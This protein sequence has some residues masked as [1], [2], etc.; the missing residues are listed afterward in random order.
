LCAVLALALAGSAHARTSPSQGD[1]FGLNVEQM[2]TGKFAPASQ[3]ARYISRFRQDGI[4]TA[5]VPVYWDR[6]EPN[7]PNSGSHY[8][9]WEIT[10]QMA[11]N[12]AAYGVRM[13][14]VISHSP[15]WASKG[16]NDDQYASFPPSSP[17][18]FG[19]FARAVAARYG[20]NGTFW[21]SRRDLPYVPPANYEIWNEEN[22]EYYW[23]PAP[24]PAYY[25]RVYEAARAGI[26]QVDP[27]V[28][29]VVGGVVWNDDAQFIR[30]LY[31]AGGPGW[32]PDGIALHPYA[33]TVIGTVINLRRIYNTL[34]SM[35]QHPPLYLSE[36]GW[37]AAPP[38][39]SGA[40]DTT[41]GPMN[42]STRAGVLSLLADATM[43]SDCNISSFV[44]YDVVEPEINLYEYGAEPN[45]TGTAFADATS[46]YSTYEENSLSVC[47]GNSTPV[48]QLLKLELDLRP[49]GNGCYKPFVAY[50]GYPIEF[51]RVFYAAQGGGSGLAITDGHGV[52]AFCARSGDEGKPMRAFAEISWDNVPALA[53]S[54]DFN[55]DPACA[56]VPGAVDR[57][58]VLTRPTLI[59]PAESLAAGRIGISIRPRPVRAGVRTRVVF[60]VT[61]KLGKR[62]T[63]V[64]GASLRIG[65]VV[66]PTNKHGRAAW[67]VNYTKPGRYRITATKL[68]AHRAVNYIRVVSSKPARVLRRHSPQVIRRGATPVTRR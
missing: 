49:S 54:D 42:A 8:Y 10:D 59:H 65:K 64:V 68:D 17:D 16:F 41:Q 39:D 1:F 53:R 7:P 27:S 43:R 40:T 50:R 22:H 12:L 31:S 25:V 26:K 6:V 18:A 19:E 20:A 28:H 21:Q 57:P 47:G 9:Q 14:I 33:T 60:T 15:R 2:F 5:R 4:A 45:L 62:R 11:A 56:V 46:R 36:L 67:Y 30:G 23:R 24:D 37:V 63:P 52:T 13:T 51:A 3:W 55:C 32:A 58:V 29:V 48:S 38:G 61:R 34:Q 44:V 35:G 66:I